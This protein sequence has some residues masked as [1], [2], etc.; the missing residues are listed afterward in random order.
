MINIFLSASVPL[1]NRDRRFMA[2]ADVIAI[3]DSVKALVTEVVPRGIIVFGGHPAIT[4]LIAL[5]LKGLGM[6]AG[7]R[8]ILYQ[9]A[10][11]TD[12]FGKENE[13]FL[14]VR[15]VPAVANSPERSLRIMRERM[16]GDTPFNAGVFIGGMEGV[17][18]EFAM[19]G[20]LHPRAARWPIASTGAAAQE[21][22]EQQGARRP[23][24][25]ADEMTYS[26][27]FRRLLAELPTTQARS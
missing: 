11:F 13:E 21:L 1:P 24:Q 12:Q 26:S 3:R 2:T 15:L 22:F 6:D 16:I 19:F 27:L 7:R 18:D 25:L 9:S 17:L 5:L 8:I 14:D 4:P 10:F 20:E 23:D